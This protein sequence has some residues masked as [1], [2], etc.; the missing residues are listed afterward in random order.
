M[1]PPHNYAPQSDRLP[2]EPVV[3]DSP[4][5]NLLKCAADSLAAKHLGRSGTREHSGAPSSHEEVS[6]YWSNRESDEHQVTD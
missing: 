3:P 1:S 6:R 2:T 4:L 5:Y